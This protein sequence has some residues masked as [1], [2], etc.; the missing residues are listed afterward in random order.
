[1][2]RFATIKST[3]RYIPEIEVPND[4][5]R[6]RFAHIPDFVDKME[7]SSA[8]RTRWWV[9]DDWATSDLA[10]PA[11]RQAVERAGR[12]PEDGQGSSREMR[13]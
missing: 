2:T 5:L 1:M 8:I 7:E 9:P 10:L 6:E 3:G 13:E 11:A 4:E 12:K